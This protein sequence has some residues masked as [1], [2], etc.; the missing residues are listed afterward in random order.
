MNRR[1][2]LKK[3]LEGIVVGSI[4]LIYNCG[5]NPIKSEPIS[6]YQ[7]WDFYDAYD[8][9]S[10]KLYKGQCDKGD[11]CLSKNQI[12]EFD[13]FI[14]KSKAIAIYYAGA[15]T[16]VDP[17]NVPFDTTVLDIILSRWREFGDFKHNTTICVKTEEDYYAKMIF[18]ATPFSFNWYIPLKEK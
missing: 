11:V 17:K 3:G 8:F 7:F 13:T 2:F 10:Q 12:P 9:S 14:H 15:D 16:L 6:G 1:E 18:P 5:K 4:P